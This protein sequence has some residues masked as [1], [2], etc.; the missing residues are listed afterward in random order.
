MFKIESRGSLLD[1]EWAP[2]TDLSHVATYNAAIGAYVAKKQPFAILL[3]GTYIKTYPAP[4]RAAVGEWQQEHRAELQSHLVGMAIVSTST[5]V[6][7][8]TI[9]FGWLAPP[10]FPKRLFATVG[11]ARAWLQQQLA[12]SNALPVGMSVGPEARGPSD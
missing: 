1:V 9:A 7:G 3:D 12:Q 11:E 5:F 4:V 2:V 6:K 10:P 8:L